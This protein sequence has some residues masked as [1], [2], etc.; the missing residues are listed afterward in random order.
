MTNNNQIYTVIGLMSG[1]SHDGIDA[2]LIRTDGYSKIEPVMAV[3]T[4]YIRDLREKISDILNPRSQNSISIETRIKAVEDTIT[5]AHVASVFELLSKTGLTPDK[6]HFIGMHGHTIDHEPAKGITRQ[7]GDA[8]YLANECNIPVIA[9]FRSAD[10]KAGGQGAPLAPIYHF[11]RADNLE[12]PLAVLNLGGVGNVTFIG[13]AGAIIAFDT[14]PANALIDD[15]VFKHTGQ[16]FDTDGAMAQS[17]KVHQD[18]VTKWLNHPYFAKMGAKSLDR[19][20]F[21]SCMK[22]VEGLSPQDGAATLTALTVQSIAK[23][24]DNLPTAPKRWVVTGGGRKNVH[25]MTELLNHLDVDVDPVENVGWNGD[26]LE[27]ECF[28]YL[29]VRRFLGLPISF[30]TTTGAPH[31]MTGGE[32][33]EPDNVQAHEA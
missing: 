13:E 16:D 24:I 12:K 17:G 20:E 7:I 27:A 22:D 15:W 14:G 6:I 9:D 10:V 18:L 3:T 8:Q 19:N 25:L 2:A 11:A 5:R 29:A 30:P 33:F 32:M 31:P 4:P 21:D 23:S 26:A 1:S 28:G